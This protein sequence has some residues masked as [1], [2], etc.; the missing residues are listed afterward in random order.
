MESSRAGTAAAAAFAEQERETGSRQGD[1]QHGPS[2]RFRLSAPCPW[3]SIDCKTDLEQQSRGD[4]CRRLSAE[5]LF[6]HQ[7]GCSTSF[8][9]GRL[10]PA[11]QRLLRRLPAR[12][13]LPSPVGRLATSLLCIGSSSL[14]FRLGFRARAARRGSDRERVPLLACLLSGYQPKRR[15]SP[16]A[17][18][19]AFV[20]AV[21]H[22]H[23]S[24]RKL[25]SATAGAHGESLTEIGQREAVLLDNTGSRAKSFRCA[26]LELSRLHL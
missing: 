25:A 5:C 10:D 26:T 20:V 3:I 1:F 11:A 17:P 18:G 13:I 21:L 12:S 19:V 7:F 24:P 14:G 16:T 23:T 4:G 2:C 9:G 8:S 22:R 15:P 6:C